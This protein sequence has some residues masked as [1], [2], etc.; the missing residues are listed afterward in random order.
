MLLRHVPYDMTVIRAL[1]K[2]YNANGRSND[3]VKLYE[4]ARIHYMSQP[5]QLNPDGGDLIT[6]FDWYPSATGTADAG[7]N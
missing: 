5:E 3:A 1:A 6:P 4:D 7:T 2:L